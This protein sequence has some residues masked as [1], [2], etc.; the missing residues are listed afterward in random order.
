MQASSGWV[1]LNINVVLDYSAKYNTLYPVTTHVVNITITHHTDRRWM[2]ITGVTSSYHR[3]PERGLFTQ[4]KTSNC[5][6]H[7]PC[8]QVSA[9]PL[10]RAG[11]TF[12]GNHKII[13][14]DNK[15]KANRENTHAGHRGT[16]QLPVGLGTLDLHCLFGKGVRGNFM[17]RRQ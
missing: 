10:R 12:Q 9:S 17:S 5:L 11:Q 3:L 4:T 14:S 1:L 8:P 15:R 2:I 13:M 6:L 7:S 16:V